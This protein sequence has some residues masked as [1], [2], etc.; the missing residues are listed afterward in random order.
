M[1]S[2][3]EL[4][5]TLRISREQGFPAELTYGA[6]V[7]KPFTAA[8]FSGRVFTFTG[9]PEIRIY[10]APPVRNFLVE[11]VNGKWLY[12]GLVHITEIT[13][14]YVHKTTSGKFV[15]IHIYTPDEMKQAQQIIDRDTTN[16][17]FPL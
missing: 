13:H 17:F 12:W 14:D 7:K 3:V 10:K 8:D 5:D 1:G 6:H 9:K 15:I 2:F 4:N 16:D 11:D